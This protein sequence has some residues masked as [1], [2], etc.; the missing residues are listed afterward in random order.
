MI[1]F[2]IEVVP[3]VL[4]PLPEK[5]SW[6]NRNL[7]RCCTDYRFHINPVRV[8]LQIIVPAIVSAIAFQWPHELLLAQSIFMPI[9]RIGEFPTAVIPDH[10][11]N[12]VVEE[13]PVL[14][15]LDVADGI[16]KSAIFAL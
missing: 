12:S 10:G 7:V 14:I 16:L 2:V 6:R 8:S 4:L 13:C 9:I 1:Q 5:R 15:D 11:S 3:S